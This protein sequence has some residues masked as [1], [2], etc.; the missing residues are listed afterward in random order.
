MTKAKGIRD[1][2]LAEANDEEETLRKGVFQAQ[3]L[4]GE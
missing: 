3:L 4:E 1:E 2:R